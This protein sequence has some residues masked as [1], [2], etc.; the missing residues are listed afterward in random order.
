MML[1]FCK[2]YLKG[3]NLI[4]EKNFF[5]VG[6]QSFQHNYC[7]QVQQN[8]ILSPVHDIIFS[9]SFPTRQLNKM[10]RIKKNADPQLDSSTSGLG[11]PPPV[12]K[13]PNINYRREKANINSLETFIELVENDIFKPSNYKRIKNNISNQER[14][15]LKDIQKDTSKAC[16]I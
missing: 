8:V 16:R 11:N 10:T 15:G 1:P 9:T 4:V 14:N 7:Y 2:I 5:Q 13:K 3:F 12:Q 6:D